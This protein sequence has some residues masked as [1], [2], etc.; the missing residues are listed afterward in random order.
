VYQHRLR[1]NAAGRIRVRVDVDD[2]P[3]RELV[4]ASARDLPT[5]DLCVARVLA[6]T[7]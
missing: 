5:G 3:G 2:A 7:A 6:P 1:T 4:I